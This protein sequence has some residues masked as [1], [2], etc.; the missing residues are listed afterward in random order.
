MGEPGVQGRQAERQLPMIVEQPRRRN[1]LQVEDHV[2]DCDAD[3]GLVI[4]DRK[5]SQ[6]QV[7]DR[8]IGMAVGA[9]DPAGQL[10]IVRLVKLDHFG[11]CALGKSAQASS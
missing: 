9:F 11:S 5:N 10:L 6:R 7:L 4:A 1:S 2:T 3:A 8:E